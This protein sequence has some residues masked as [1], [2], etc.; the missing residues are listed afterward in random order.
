[1]QPTT[2]TIGLSTALIRPKISATAAR[3]PTLDAVEPAVSSMPGSA[4]VATSSATALIRT[5]MT[6]R[7]RTSCH[8]RRHGHDVAG[9]SLP[10]EVDEDPAEVFGVLLDAVVQ[11][12]D[13][14]LLQEPEHVL[15]ELAGALARDDLDQRRLL[16]DRLVHDVAQ[17]PVDV[18]AAV[19]DVVQVER[20]LHRSVS[21]LADCRPRYAHRQVR[22]RP[23]GRPPTPRE[24]ACASPG[25]PWPLPRRSW[26]RPSPGPAPSR[27]AP[28]AR[29][30]RPPPREA[31]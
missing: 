11:R 1:M 6:N 13:L 14:L 26:P 3:V 16:P 22:A 23:R 2:L 5:R 9:R 24:T 25:L 31:S 30:P 20:E 21:G 28:P 19:V 7:M 4:H 8:D 29:L 12:L 27:A 17:R 15:L 18:P 10:A